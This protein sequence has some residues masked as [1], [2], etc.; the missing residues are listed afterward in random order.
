MFWFVFIDLVFLPWHYGR[1]KVWKC[2]VKY[3]EDGVSV[4]EEWEF[5]TMKFVMYQ[6]PYEHFRFELFFTW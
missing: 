2:G 1:G 6:I 4:S 5:F 3:L